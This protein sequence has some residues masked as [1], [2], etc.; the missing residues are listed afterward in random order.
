MA[1]GGEG[2]GRVQE[3]ADGFVT[4]VADG[5]KAF[6][7]RV[8]RVVEAGGVLDAEHDRMRGGTPGGGLDMGREQVL[9]GDAVMVEEAVGGF[10]L[11]PGAAGLGE[12]RGGLEGEVSGHG[13]QAGDQ[14]WIGQRGEGK[15]VRGP[16]GAGRLSRGSDGCVALKH[17]AINYITC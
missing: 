16:V 10:G 17:P 9:R 8:S 13:D 12:G 6:G 2:Q 3:Q 4:V 1:G 7:L 15:F 5:A 14:A 11:G